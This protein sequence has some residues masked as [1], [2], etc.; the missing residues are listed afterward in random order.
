MPTI[1]EHVSHAEA[2]GTRWRATPEAHLGRD[3]TST[4]STKANPAHPIG[5][6]QLISGNHLAFSAVTDGGMIRAFTDCIPK[7]RMRN[8]SRVE[9]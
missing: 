6:H 7:L 3:Q 5:K 8:L 4:I 9:T 1:E 2:G